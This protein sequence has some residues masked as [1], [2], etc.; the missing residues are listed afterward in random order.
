MKQLRHYPWADPPF[1]RL[2]IEGATR[3]HARCRRTLVGFETRYG[4]VPALP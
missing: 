3:L 4:T 2:I 1:H